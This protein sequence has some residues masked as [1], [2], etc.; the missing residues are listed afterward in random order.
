V[1]RRMFEPKLYTYLS[2]VLQ[3][4][5]WALAAS[6]VSSSFYTVGRTP[7]TR[8]QPVARPIPTRKTAQ[9]QIKR[10]QASMPR[11]GLEPTI[12]VFE[13]EKTVYALY[14]VVT[15]IGAL[16]ISLVSKLSSLLSLRTSKLLNQ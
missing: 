10:T 11:E 6:S 16:Y 2:M 9:T 4:F 13:Q 7:C 5:C 14:C 3:S 1:S 12:P 8:D 15:V